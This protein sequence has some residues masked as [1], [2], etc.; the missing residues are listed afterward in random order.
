[1]KTKVLFV[2]HKF[3]PAVGGMEKQCYEL[4]SGIKDECEIVMIRLLKESSRIYWLATLQSRVT[5]ALK[6]HP[7][8]THVYFNDGLCGLAAKAVRKVSSAVTVVTLHGL[9][10]VFPNGWFQRQLK[11]NL[12]KNVDHSI[13]VSSATRDELLKRGIPKEK[14]TVIPNGVDLDISHKKGDAEFEQILSEKL[15][16]DVSKKKMLV[17]IGRSVKRKGFSWF[18][19]QVMPKLGDEYIYCMIGPKQKNIAF[20]STLFACTPQIVEKQVSL[21][22]IG[23]DQ[24]KISKLLKRKE[25][26]ARVF[27]LGAV[28]HEDKIRLLQQAHAF[29]M[30]NIKI[31]GDAEGFGLVALEAVLSGA[32]VLASNIEGIT[33]AIKTGKNGRLVES[34]NPEAWLSAIKEIPDDED[35]RRSLIDRAITFTRENYSWSK[36]VEEYKKILCIKN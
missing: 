1:M 6:E 18:I 15:G 27:Q 7:D 33:E 8:I 13:A 16:L 21:M 14:I 11:E 36:M 9:D 2:T 31:S 12:S 24:K 29:V 32:P 34:G 30:P 20:Y 35:L 19:E 5:K 28:P 17:S 22:G 26:N 25:L 3:P 23:M 4:Y 10:V